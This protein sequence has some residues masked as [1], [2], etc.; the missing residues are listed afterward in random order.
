MFFGVQRFSFGCFLEF[1]AL[2]LD[3]FWNTT[4]WM[5]FGVQR[6]SAVQRFLAKKLSSLK[7]TFL[8]NNYFL[9]R[10]IE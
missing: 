5:F 6:F 9:K 8:D 3:V 10:R 4:L 7:K 1:N 2:A